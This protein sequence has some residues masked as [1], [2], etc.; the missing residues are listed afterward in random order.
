MQTVVAVVVGCVVGSFTGVLAPV[1]T[2]WLRNRERKQEREGEIQKDLRRMIER[3]LD[4]CAGAQVAVFHMLTDMFAGISPAEAYDRAITDQRAKT[5]THRE[6]KWEPYRIRDE[7]LRSLVERL[8]DALLDFETHQMTA[9][10]MSPDEWQAV[11]TERGRNLR[12]IEHQVRLR[13]DEL[14][15]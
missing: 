15:W 4:D 1:V 9:A 8:H 14:R 5:A 2:H 11:I 3:R 12:E 10:A 6:H 7:R 13:L